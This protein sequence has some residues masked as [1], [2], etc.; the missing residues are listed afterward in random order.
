MDLPDSDTRDG[1]PGADAAAGEPLVRRLG[2]TVYREAW[3]A[4]QAFTDHRDA[5]TRDELW[6]TEHPPVYTLGLAGRPDHLHPAA[7]EGAIEIVRTDRGGQVT[8]HGPGQAVMYVLL[9][10]RRRRLGVRPLVRMLEQAVIDCL[11][12]WEIEAHGRVDAPGVYVGAAKIAALGLKVRRGASYHGLALN[13]DMDLSP[14]DA[15]DPCG[16]PGL[17][18]TQARALGIDDSTGEMADRLAALFIA[19]LQ[20]RFPIVPE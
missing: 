13:V 12:G 14:F 5:A 2:T 6:L 8:Y 9:D 19:S 11:G 3:A 18:V 17:A 7:A 4:M 20:A 1:V 10:L 15:I 16:Y